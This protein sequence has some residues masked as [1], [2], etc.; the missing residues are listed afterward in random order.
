MTVNDLLP[1]NLFF[2]KKLLFFQ[3]FIAPFYIY[4]KSR[5]KV[6]YI[7]VDDDLIPQKIKLKSSISN[8]IF[9]KKTKQVDFDITLHKK[10]ISKIIVKENYKITEFD[11]I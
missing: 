4:L 7:N 5:Y 9:N 3:D 1:V 8:F 10:N 2:S 11:I 6:R